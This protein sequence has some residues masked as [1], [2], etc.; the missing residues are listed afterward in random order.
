MDKTTEF[1]ESM[2]QHAAPPPPRIYDPV[3]AHE[4]YIK[5]RE[6]KGRTGAGLKTAKQKEGFAYVKAKLTESQKVE[7]FLVSAQNKAKMEAIKNDIKK[8]RDELSNKIKKLQLA[9]KALPPL[10]KLPANPTK[11]DRAKY[12]E[13]RAK[14]NEQ[15]AALN[16]S[17]KA[18]RDKIM[19][20]RGKVVD[21]LKSSVE[22]TRTEFKAAI[23]GIKAKYATQL[24]SEFNALKSMK[25]PK[26][27]K[28]KPRQ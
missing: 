3:K 27:S 1:I 26:S 23:E 17:S 20:E 9:R 13:E 25:A 11:E 15:R 2:F 4:Y 18:E 14:Y 10:P 12:A 7:Q 8:R 22:K 5:T 21:D 19:E 28:S 6:L 24:D 16:E